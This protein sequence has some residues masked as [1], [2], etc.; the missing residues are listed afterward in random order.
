MIIGGGMRRRAKI[1]RPTTRVSH[2]MKN[3]FYLFYIAGYALLVA[4][5][6][7]CGQQGMTP[8]HFREIVKA[9]GDAVPLIPAMTSLPYW[10]NAA[11]SNVM[12]YADGRVVHEQLSQ[13]AR[14]V[15]GQY[16]V[17]NIYSQLNR[18]WM[19]SIMA[20]DEAAKA[21]KVYGLYTDI[22]GR[23]MLTAGTITY[24]RAKGTYRETSAFGNGFREI[25]D[26]VHT[27]AR[28]SAKSMVYQGGRLVLS[29]EATTWP[30][31]GK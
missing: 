17:F 22:R 6:S 27:A 31:R 11:G 24:D 30:V 16:V 28:D 12:T 20:Y 29:R 25:T 1:V 9:P 7:G 13:T 5:G 15:R 21:V 3:L 23:D 18:D 10:T 2:G 14:T 4:V 26:G 19:N 8:A